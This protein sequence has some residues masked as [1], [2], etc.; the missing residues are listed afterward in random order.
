MQSP[1]L[2]TALGLALMAGLSQL[3]EAGD[4]PTKRAQFGGIPA[5]PAVPAIPNAPATPGMVPGAV[6]GQYASPYAAPGAI[7][8][9]VY[10]GAA[11]GYG[12]GGGPYGAPGGNM[13]VGNPYYWSNSGFNAGAYP[14]YHSGSV[15]PYTPVNSAPQAMGDPY[16]FHYGPGFYRSNESGNLR[17]PYYSYRRPW[18]YYGQPSY[19]RDT[20]L[21]W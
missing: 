15:N 5:A 10:G 3:S 11:P 13:A 2:R 21:P 9:G 18:Y 4:V 14:L 20:N 1:V 16:S 17:F 8:G 12:A 19:D 6:P 7:G